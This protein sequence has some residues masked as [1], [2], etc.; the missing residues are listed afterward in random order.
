MLTWELPNF[1]VHCEQ[2]ICGVKITCRY[3]SAGRQKGTAQLKAFWLAVRQ[4][5]VGFHQRLLG[6]TLEAGPVIQ[7][8]FSRAI[9]VAAYAFSLARGRM[10]AQ[11]TWLRIICAYGVAAL[12]PTLLPN[13]HGDNC[14]VFTTIAALLPPERDHPFFS[15]DT[16]NVYISKF[17]ITCCF[18]SG[19]AA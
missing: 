16:F 10:L 18:A 14:R 15:L 1:C 6:I 12:V 13:A 17:S 3:V 11:P 5:V 19:A 8:L 7:Q 4:S 2:S 9:T